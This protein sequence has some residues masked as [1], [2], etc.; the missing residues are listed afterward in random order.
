MRGPPKAKHPRIAAFRIRIYAP[1]T[2]FLRASADGLGLATPDSRPEKA[3]T[4][5]DAA[6]LGRLTLD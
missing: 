6:R 4:T 2:G 1:R 3:T 5:I